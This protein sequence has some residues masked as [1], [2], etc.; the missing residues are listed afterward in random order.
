MSSY[1]LIFPRVR[2]SL[3]FSGFGLKPSASGFQS[4]SYSSPRL[5]H[6]YSTDDKTSRLMM[7][8]FSTVRDTQRGSQ[9]YM[10]RRRGRREIEVTRRRRGRIYSGKSS[11]ASN[12]F[13]MCSPQSGT[14]REVQRIT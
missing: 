9:S 8:R 5:L 11:L 2:S 4:Y 12:Q 14:L 6:P 1:Q 7:K 10:K 13:P 3:V